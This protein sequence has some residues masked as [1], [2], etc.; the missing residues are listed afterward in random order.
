VRLIHLLLREEGKQMLVTAMTVYD[1]DF[2][3]AVARHLAS[4]FLK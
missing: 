1:D 2:L 3:A 4:G